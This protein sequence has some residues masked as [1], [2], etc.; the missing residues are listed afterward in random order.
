MG[1]SYLRYE[2]VMKGSIHS[3][4]RCPVCGSRFK[5]GD[6]RRPLACPKHPDV[7]PTRFVLRYGRHLTKR[8][9][10]YESA[11][12]FLTGLRFKDG[13]GDLDLR[14]YQIK[15]RPLAFDRLAEEWLEVK[16]GQVKLES[17][18]SLAVAIRR[19]AEVWRGANI[20]SIGYA[21]VED[22]LGRLGRLAPKS[23]KHT[24]D[25]LKQFWDW[26][27]DRHNVPPL[28]KWPRL[29]HVE[30][31]FRATVDLPTQETIIQ[32][33]KEH[34]PFRVWLCVKWLATYIAIRPG[35]MRSLTEGQ[36]DRQ[37]GLLIVP[38]PKEKRAKIIPLIQEDMELARGL[39][40]AFNQA[41]PFFRHETA[42]GGGYKAGRIF[43]R[44]LL[45]RAWKRA[46]ARLGIEGVSLYPGT[47]HSTAM[48]L[49]AIYTP[50][51]IQA[52]TL[53]RTGASFRRYF[54]TG[55]EDLRRLL[56]GRQTLTQVD[57]GPITRFKD[58]DNSHILEFIDK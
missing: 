56:E 33:I 39:P 19:A 46:C 18:R 12:Q 9:S 32:N 29:G 36:I 21:Q 7:Q 1:T 57:N 45:Y 15:A 42:R 34:E 20:K 4:Q 5:S 17:L 49:R 16:A 23:R 25:A 8:F 53:H 10:D 31:A 37:R 38:H 47:K 50:E 55:G 28:R 11:L 54:Q 51:Q 2:A 26:A 22:L 13:S 40:L 52:Q 44:T 35:E 14:D 48:G 27:V 6:G 43:G 24:L 30:M 3:D 58:N 41:S